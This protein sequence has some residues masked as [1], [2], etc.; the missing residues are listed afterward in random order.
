MKKISVIFIVFILAGSLLM[1][2]ADQR[3]KVAVM[4]FDFSSIQR[5][6]SGNWDIGK[7]VSDLI[8]KN[9]VN[10]GTYR[11]IERRALDAILAEQNFSNSDR[12][13][14]STAAAIGK[15]LGVDAI[16]L[17]SI[18]QF[19]T[20]DKKL[21]IGGFGRK[22][23][24]F[25][26]GKIGTKSGKAKV[27][28][29]ARIVDINTAEIIGVAEGEG[30]SKRSGLL[31]AGAGGG[32]GGMGGG[33]FDMGASN[34]RDTILGEATHAA[35][36]EV[37]DGLV[38]SSGR[39]QATVRTVSVKGLVAFAQD[40]LVVLNVGSDHGV[41]PGMELSV[42][43]VTQ[44]IKDPATGKV[45]REL[46]EKIGTIKVTKVDGGSAEATAL[47]GSNFQVGDVVKN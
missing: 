44:V 35:A 39:I 37:S 12:A 8:V 10:D 11:V 3:K 46:T 30:E 26:I 5:W 17:G 38:N 25:G 16:I 29:D 41:T 1:G 32:S 22:I 27:V 34:F 36:D 24:G 20:E 23:G 14:P 42:E 13:N 40:S 15:I 43:R 7:G 18:T 9:L 4:D 6:W 33:S 2:A 47:S 31:L 28:V 19:G 21:G 45:L